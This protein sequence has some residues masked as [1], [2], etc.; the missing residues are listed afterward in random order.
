[1]FLPGLA[2]APVSPPGLLLPVSSHSLHLPLSPVIRSAFCLNPQFSDISKKRCF[3]FF[4]FFSC[5][6]D[7]NMASKLFTFWPDNG[8]MNLPLFSNPFLFQISLSLEKVMIFFSLT[9][10]NKTV[11]KLG[12]NHI[13]AHLL[14]FGNGL[15]HFGSPCGSV[16]GEGVE[17]CW[18]ALFFFSEMFL[19]FVYNFSNLL[20]KSTL[21]SSSAGTRFSTES[22]LVLDFHLYTYSTLPFKEVSGTC[23]SSVICPGLVLSSEGLSKSLMR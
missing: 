10:E 11:I 23:P 22:F 9:G 8:I 5:G 17:G 21:L 7:R 18:Q 6:E 16:G 13:S 14:L 19:I 12:H 4:S 1:M 2:R 3:V 15:W 20:S